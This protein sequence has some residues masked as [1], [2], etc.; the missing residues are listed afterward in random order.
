MVKRSHSI[1]GQVCLYLFCLWE[2]FFFC[3]SRHEKKFPD[4]KSRVVHPINY[5]RARNMPL[6]TC[7]SAIALSDWPYTNNANSWR[8]GAG[9]QRIGQI[10]RAVALFQKRKT[11]VDSSLSRLH[12]RVSP[13]K[14]ISNHQGYALC[15]NATTAVIINAML[16]SR[17]SC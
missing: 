12:F 1:T 11:P 10:K 13:Q 15:A 14:A 16:C 6:H 7:V 17:H 4:T 8:M 5:N 9:R 3:E 2:M